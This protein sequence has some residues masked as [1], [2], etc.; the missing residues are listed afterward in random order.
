MSLPRL[1]VGNFDFEHRL[2]DP[3]RVL[4]KR[5]DSIN[6]DLAWSWLALAHDGD[7]IWMPRKTDADA[8]AEIGD[9]F[10]I[11]VTP[12]SDWRAVET[13][14][15]LVP[16]GWTDGLLQIAKAKQWQHPAIDPTAVKEVNS[17]RCSADFESIWSVGL[18]GADAWCSINEITKAVE[19]LPEPWRWV[20][21]AE[22]GMS[23]RERCVGAGQLTFATTNW[24][25]RHLDDSGIVFFEPWVDR[26]DE[27][28]ILF[29]LPAQGPLTLVGVAP[30]LIS[31]NGHYRGSWFALPP[32]KPPWWE[33]AVAVATRAAEAI[34]GVGYVGPLGMDAMLYRQPDGTPAVRPLQDINARWTMGRL[35][36]NWRERF[37]DATCGYWWH[38]PRTAFEA[39]E[40]LAPW[41]LPESPQVVMTSPT[42]GVDH[43]SVLV[44]R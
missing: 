20:I 15:E 38:G 23:G 12:V 33:D 27:V 2:A 13:A 37:P 22:F 29:D 19:A 10:N 21:K 6:A 24:V 25:Q 32:D 43:V 40:H 39:N 26:L 4:P 14:V 41:P 30:M 31:P 35:A 7:F 8:I 42:T 34:Q 36:W 9:R 3:H 28:G 44:W 18:P 17:R 5:L 16:W 11:R 1:F